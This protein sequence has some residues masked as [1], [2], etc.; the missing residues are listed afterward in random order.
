MAAAV[1]QA[2]VAAHVQVAS[3]V[4]GSSSTG[5][6][7]TRP[8][9]WSFASDVANRFPPAPASSCK[10]GATLNGAVLSSYGWAYSIK[11]NKAALEAVTPG[12]TLRLNLASE[13]GAT[14]N[15]R[16]D[17]RQAHMVLGYI[18]S[19]D[20]FGKVSLACRGAACTCAHATIDAAWNSSADP[21]KFRSILEMSS[22][23]PVHFRG[24]GACEL[25][26]QLL[27]QTSSLG[28]K[29]RLSAL[30]LMDKVANHAITLRNVAGKGGLV[31]WL[32]DDS[33]NRR[34]FDASV[35]GGQ[36]LQL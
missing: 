1:V 13:P 28:N 21:R 20:N 7:E 32:N 3:T 29:F 30:L 6:S 5:S 19:R 26:V 8:Q 11:Y 31:T 12:S 4:K 22:P 14:P 36:H 35:A 34:R 25:H 15:A 2:L 10:L 18:K 27:H 23:I 16:H 33:W 24:P 9:A 17:R